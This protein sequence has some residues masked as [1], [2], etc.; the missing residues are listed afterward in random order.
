MKLSDVIFWNVDTQIDFIE[1]DGKLYAPGAETIKPVL[2]KLTK[3]AEKHRIRVVSTCD[4]HFV[5]SAELSANP[6]FI[7]TFPEHC[8][9]G[10]RGA[11]FIPETDPV[12]PV[13]IDWDH[14]V[15]LYP[16]LQDEERFRNI[17]IR[18]DDFDVFKG[19][20]NA[21]K[22]L[23]FVNKDTFIVYGVTTN[24]C[25]HKAVKGLVE[26]G[27]Q[28]YVIEDAIKELPNI[29]LPFKEWEKMGVKMISFSKLKKSL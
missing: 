27:K 23:E 24:V 13:T 25:V 4:Y 1:P 19:N 3:L 17:V 22:V 10:T 21:E 16:E 7:D 2:D 11:Q 9:A 12:L 28:V 20:P 15:T 26:R 14:E 18:K 5:N 8:M 6:N 29:P